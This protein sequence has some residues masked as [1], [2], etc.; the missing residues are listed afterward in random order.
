MIGDNYRVL[1]CA[2]NCCEYL[3]HDKLLTGK[4]TLVRRRYIFIP[5]SKYEHAV[6]NVRQVLYNDSVKRFI[7]IKV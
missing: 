4:D 5:A 6:N 7:Q 3:T 1:L 2:R